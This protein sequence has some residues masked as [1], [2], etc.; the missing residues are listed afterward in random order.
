MSLEEEN[1]KK[2]KT[3]T[4]SNNKID[5]GDVAAGATGIPNM[6]QKA[7]KELRSDADEKIDRGDVASGATGIPNME[8]KANK[9]QK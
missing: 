8:Q 9:K 3:E 2:S 6:E 4:D 5:R 7:N 1:R